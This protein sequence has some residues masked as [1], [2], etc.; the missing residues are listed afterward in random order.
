[1]VSWKDEQNWQPLTMLG[2]RRVGK[3]QITKMKDEK[4][5]ITTDLIEIAR[6][7]IVLCKNKSQ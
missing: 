5:N 6:I 3:S 4:Q 2:E 1:M 7:W